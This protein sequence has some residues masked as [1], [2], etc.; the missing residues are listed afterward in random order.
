[1]VALMAAGAGISQQIPQKEK[2][3]GTLIKLQA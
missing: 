1:M 2:E 3:G